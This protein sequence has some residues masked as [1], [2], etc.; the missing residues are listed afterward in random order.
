MD[1][2]GDNYRLQRDIQALKTPGV[3]VVSNSA[4]NVILDFFAS[5]GI[6]LL[7]AYVSIVLIAAVSLVRV[8]LR[9]REFDY[10]FSV[11]AASWLGYQLQSIISINQIGLAIWG[12]LL[13]GALIGFEKATRIS[14][15]SDHSKKSKPII[16]GKSTQSQVF[17]GTLL[18]GLGSI[19][20]FL[21][22]VPPLSADMSWYQATKTGNLVEIEKA[23]IPG[24]LHPQE[25]SRL[26]NVVGLLEN[27]QLFDLSL[28]YA[29]KATEFN[30]NNFDS[31]NTLYSI[32]NSSPE[33]KALALENMK[34]L[35]PLNPDVTK[36]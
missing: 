8:I 4:H 16:A 27:N 32:K 25:S 10:V 26:V 21:L 12:W 19:F 29:L 18:A 3:Q 34:R 36:R 24:Y 1:A 9:K 30:P 35:D 7:I 14:E 22:V 2:Y 31:W 11:L 13:S 15:L 23:L 6:L 33:Q 28:K 5:G 20:G 17:S